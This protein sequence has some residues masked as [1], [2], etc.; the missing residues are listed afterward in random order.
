[1]QGGLKIR[2]YTIRL[3]ETLD[4]FR[5]ATNRPWWVSEV[6]EGTSIDLAPAS[7][8]SQR[9]G[10]ESSVRLAVAELLVA[11]HST[12]VP[13]G[14]ASARRATLRWARHPSKPHRRKRMPD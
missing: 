2:P 13:H 11:G 6:A 12:V 7:V 3:H 14:F 1:M 8:L 10:V 9:G 4:S 5:L